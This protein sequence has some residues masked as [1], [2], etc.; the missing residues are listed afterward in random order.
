MKVFPDAVAIP[1]RKDWKN[2]P[3][4]CGIATRLLPALFN[5]RSRHLLPSGSWR[6]L[7]PQPNV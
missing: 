7:R 4:A 6:G 5:F 2:R 3:L 1:E